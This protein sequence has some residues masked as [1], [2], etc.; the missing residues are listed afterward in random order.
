VKQNYKWL[1]IYPDSF[2]SDVE[3]LMAWRRMNGLCSRRISIEK[4]NRSYGSI[5]DYIQ[6]L[7]DKQGGSL[8]YV[9]L[10]GGACI[11]APPGYD[12]TQYNI[13]PIDIFNDGPS[14]IDASLYTSD[15]EVGD[16]TGDGYPEIS[17]GRIPAENSY[18]VASYIN[19][20]LKYESA[21]PGAWEN[22]VTYFIDAANHNDCSG[23]LAQ[24]YAEELKGY[25]PV[26]YNLH[27]MFS[28]DS[29]YTDSLNFPPNGLTYCRTPLKAIEE[30]NEG[31]SLVLG[32]GN[33]G[34]P[35]NA[36]SWM[37][38]HI[39]GSCPGYFCID[40]L[41]TNEIFPF[42]IGAASGLGDLVHLRDDVPRPLVKELMFDSERGIIGAF[43][44]SNSRESWLTGN[45]IISKYTLQYLYEFGAKSAGYACMN[46]QK[47]VMEEGDRYDSMIRAFIY[48]GDP[49]IEIKGTTVLTDVG[50]EAPPGGLKNRLGR[51]YPNP[52]NPTTTIEYNIAEDS[53]INLS[54][55]NVAGRFVRTLAEGFK[56][57]GSY[58]VTW[59][60]CDQRGRKV[61]SG[62]YF[63]R[64][65]DG[66]Y[67]ETRKLILLR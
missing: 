3:D 8:E 39:H 26:D 59:H 22:E 10:V 13:I 36:V 17:V 16:V 37:I 53:E 51:N 4:I 52:F 1:A 11:S 23:R 27:Y 41:T 28:N 20:V 49:A 43:G 60:G 24:R 5:N 66:T 63:Y 44:P 14:N 58:R 7:W 47:A 34:N 64:I 38:G 62:V 21:A 30:F 45:F 32:F 57:A 35:W 67:K 42:F 55:Y 65:N 15:F 61:S 31:R 46:A 29:T 56:E 40:S 12:I 2:K 25:L 9:C 48:F 6:Y 33:A 50:D 18:D 54:I 19:K